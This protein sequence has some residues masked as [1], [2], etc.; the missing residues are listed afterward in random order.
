MYTEFDL[1]ASPLSPKKV[2]NSFPEP[3]L[4]P[5]LPRI[6][7]PLEIKPNNTDF[8]QIPTR[9]KQEIPAMVPNLPPPIE[10]AKK[11]KQSTS[12]EESIKLIMALQ[13]EQEEKERQQTKDELMCE[14]CRKVWP[15]MTK[16]F[17]PECCH[18]M[19]KDHIIQT[20]IARY[21]T[22]N[23]ISCPKEG[24][25]YVLCNEELED[26]IGKKE[27]EELGNNSLKEFIGDDAMI[28]ECICGVSSIVDPGIVDYTYKDE[29]GA[30][31]SRE[32]AEHMAKYRFRCAACNR[33]ICAKCKVEPYHLGKTCEE[34]QNF[35]KSKHCR[36][37]QKVVH[38]SRPVC[39]DPVCRARYRTACRKV[40]SCGHQC[41][42]VKHETECL[43]CIADG[44]GNIANENDYCTICYTEGLGAAPCVQLECGHVLHYHCVLTSLE[45][46]WVGPRI[47]FNFAKCPSCKAW[48]NAPNNEKISIKMAEI[49]ELYND[50][51]GKAVKRLKFE[52][53]EKDARLT[54]PED[55][56]YKQPEKYAMDRF[57]YYECFKCKK[58]YFGGKKECEQNMDRGNYEASELVCP[59]C[60][61]VGLE[62]QTCGTHGLEFIE[63]KCKF[64]CNIAAWFCWGNTHFCDT[65]H[66]QQNEGNYLTKKKKEE[67]PKCPGPS[68]CPLKIRHPAN[69]EEFAL[70]CSICR[71]LRANELGF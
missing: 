13:R 57:A 52:G 22:N 63:F 67:L 37:C 54:N 32:T 10:P 24:C 62:G 26:L 68:L 59:G 48:A 28:V 45:K 33:V 34:H 64:C 2:D 18:M 30:G 19:C 29:N 47:T 21:P 8:I 58:P 38:S 43:P 9:K 35:K 70:G 49:I 12:E 65:C 55:H 17:F 11:R 27:L 41:F 23:K 4:P 3:I 61:A 44:C 50:I 71:N 39:K 16:M 25:E 6:K 51:I 20:I 60:A 14:I 5:E 1:I 40:H 15:D 42:G 7:N 46:R 36:Y 31:I 56:Y 53:M 66:T 69:G